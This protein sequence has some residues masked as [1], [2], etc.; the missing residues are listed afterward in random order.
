MK[1]YGCL[2]YEIY[3]YTLLACLFVCPFVSNKRKNGWTYRVQILKGPHMT[4]AREGFWMLKI[5]KMCVQMFL[6][7]VK[8]WKFWN[9]FVVIVL[10]CQQR[11]S[12]QIEQQKTIEI[13]D[14][15]LIS[16]SL[17]WKSLILQL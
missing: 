2:K 10:Y 5:T 4:P 9:F 13:E 15:T 8:F 16:L 6:K 11:R 1:E 3:K 14:G 17:F 7:F 12:S